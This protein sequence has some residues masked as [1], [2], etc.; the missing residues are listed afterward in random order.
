VDKELEEAIRR[1]EKDKKR[2]QKKEREREAKQDLR[3]KMSVIAS[4]S[5][6]NDDELTLDRKTWEKL[7]QIDIDEVHKYIPKE[8]TEEEEDPLERKYKFL[9]DGGEK[10]DKDSEDSDADSVD[11]K[12]KRVD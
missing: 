12:V 4:T 8:E 6:N 3:K 2:Q 10:P 11:D 7:R 1:L 5:I 9:T